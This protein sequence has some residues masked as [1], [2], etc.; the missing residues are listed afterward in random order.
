MIDCGVG[1]SAKEHFHELAVFPGE[2]AFGAFLVSR[3]AGKPF[4]FERKFSAGHQHTA[5]AAHRAGFRPG[6]FF[7]ELL[8]EFADLAHIFEGKVHADHKFAQRVAHRHT[9]HSLFHYTFGHATLSEVDQCVGFSQV[10]AA[11]RALFLGCLLDHAFHHGVAEELTHIK[12]HAVFAGAVLVEV[13]LFQSLDATGEQKGTGCQQKKNV[14]RHC[15]S[16][17]DLCK[18]HKSTP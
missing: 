5:H 2:E 7:T 16:F 14:F 11:F 15:L 1:A 3:H 12:S 8:V 13:D 6:A 9:H 18:Q 10:K 17:L 4:L